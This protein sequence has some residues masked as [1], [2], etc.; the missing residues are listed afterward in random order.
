LRELPATSVKLDRSLIKDI[1]NQEKDRRLVPTLLDLAQRLGY[2][3]VAEGIENQ[4][5]FNT[6]KAWGCSEGQ[7][8]FIAPPLADQELMQWLSQDGEAQRFTLAQH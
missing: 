1:Q 8:F 4:A 6:V 5:N 7:G 3:V 2:K